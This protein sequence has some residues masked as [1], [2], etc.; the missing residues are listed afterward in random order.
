MSQEIGHLVRRLLPAPRWIIFWVVVFFFVLAVVIFFF[1]PG[2][3][4]DENDFTLTAPRLKAE[5]DIRTIGLQFLAGAVLGL[6]ALFTA[7]TLVFNRESQI[8]ERF[9]RAVDQLGHDTRDVRVGGIYALERIARDSRRDQEPIM[10]VL[11]TFIREHAPWMEP[12]G[13]SDEPPPP[14]AADVQAAL[15]VLGRR[16]TRH[17]IEPLPIDVSRT[18]LR[19]ATFDRL[20]FERANLM[21]SRLEHARFFGANLRGVVLIGAHL[22]HARFED[23]DLQKALLNEADLR[24]ASFGDANLKGAFLPDANLSEAYLGGADLTQAYLKGAILRG[25]TYDRFTLWPAGFDPEAAGA[26]A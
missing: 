18:D 25:A 7:I 8:T 22:Q 10:E 11:A 13:Y 2:W 12:H 5:N 1:L 23:A 6:G 4:V 24:S 15:T 19:S 14:P 16:E 20:K 3:M 21:E 17:E 9:T 26:I